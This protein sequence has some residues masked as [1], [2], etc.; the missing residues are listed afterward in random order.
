M[1]ASTS[2]SASTKSKLV[3]LNVKC[4]NAATSSKFLEKRDSN[5]LMA[6]LMFGT[7][8]SGEISLHQTAKLRREN[9]QVVNG[10]M[11]DGGLRGCICRDPAPSIGRSVEH[12]DSLCYAYE[13]SFMSE[14]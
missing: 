5:I 10:G 3:V 6:V 8:S 4:E 14:F 2:T 7:G 13:A 11:A 12:V 9:L 1:I